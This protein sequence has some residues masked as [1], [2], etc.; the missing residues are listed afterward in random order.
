MLH[1]DAEIPDGALDLGVAEQEL[2]RP[3]I[4]GA[5]VDQRYLGS[6][7]RVGAVQMRVEPDARESTRRT[8]ARTAVASCL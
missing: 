6:P 3:Q 8:A 2:D 7:Q 1:L 5:P 4:A